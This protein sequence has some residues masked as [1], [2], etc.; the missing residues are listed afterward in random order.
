[1]TSH[2]SLCVNTSEL[3]GEHQSDLQVSVQAWK[4]D[5]PLYCGTILTEPHWL[6]WLLPAAQTFLSDYSTVPP[7][8]PDIFLS[9]LCV[10]RT[11]PGPNHQFRK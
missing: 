8:L 2:H 11:L 7:Q 1:M 10:R 5:F 3:E 6:T 9:N 4:N